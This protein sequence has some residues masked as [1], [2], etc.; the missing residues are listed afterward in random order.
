[1][2]VEYVYLYVQLIVHLRLISIVENNFDDQNKILHLHFSCFKQQQK[3][4][5]T[6]YCPS[7]DYFIL[8]REKAARRKKSRGE[9]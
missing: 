8:K 3:K 2:H 4:K 5:E 7:S 9:Q 6:P 1:M